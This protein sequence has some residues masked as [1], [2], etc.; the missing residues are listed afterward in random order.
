LTVAELKALLVED[1]AIPARAAAVML[2]RVGCEV[3]AIVDTGE[4]ALEAAARE[5]PDLVLMDIRLKGSM[6]GIE[7]AALIRERFDI[8]I[9]FVSAYLAEE[10]HDP[11]V[12]L[13]GSLYLNKPI[14]EEALAAAVRGVATGAAQNG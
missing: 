1:E 2:A 9:V 4:K 6:D 8:P 7:A 12:E 11:R 14:D 13:A 3:V 5:H 10:L